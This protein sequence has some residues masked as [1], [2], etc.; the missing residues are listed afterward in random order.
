MKKGQK[1]VMNGVNCGLMEDQGKCLVTDYTVYSLTPMKGRW[2]L[3]GE[4]CRRLAGGV[5]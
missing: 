4:I 1:R 3:G 5:C 2:E